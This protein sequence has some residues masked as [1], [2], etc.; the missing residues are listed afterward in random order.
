[1]QI[2]MNTQSVVTTERPNRNNKFSNSTDF[3]SVFKRQQNEREI[4]SRTKNSIHEDSKKSVECA[5][6]STEQVADRQ[7]TEN[8]V[9][10]NPTADN[11]VNDKQSP[12]EVKN[13]P[14]EELVEEKAEEISVETCDEIEVYANQHTVLNLEL[15]LTELE[16]LLGS[17]VKDESI[18]ESIDEIK[19]LLGE[20][21]KATEADLIALNNQLS[22]LLEE[23]VAITDMYNLFIGTEDVFSTNTSGEEKFNQIIKELE[24][25]LQK[26]NKSPNN[27]KNDSHVIKAEGIENTETNETLKKVQDLLNIDKI[28]VVVTNEKSK[29]S[30]NA[31]EENSTTLSEVNQ[32]EKSLVNASVLRDKPSVFTKVDFDTQEKTS[33]LELKKV[34]SQIVEKVHVSIA[35]NKNEM[36]IKLTPERLGNVAV[37]IIVEKGIVRATLYA[38]NYQVREMLESN[39]EQLRTTLIEKGLSIES[40]D[41]SV[42]Q[43]QE[44]FNR[45]RQSAYGRKNGKNE[46]NSQIDAMHQSTTYDDNMTNHNPYIKPTQFEMLA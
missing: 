42:G 12:D 17:S 44:Q 36:L 1:M 13:N 26:I 22:K 31:K 39:I 19:L 6:N 14:N 24:L 4:S 38:E 40:L 25:L 45:F 9:N 35:N 3:S 5:K 2:Q 8:Q 32:D 16:K 28:E 15:L 43:Y 7:T 23:I 30:S 11:Q 27:E 18:K 10:D 41:V 33:A 21:N 34:I 29:S 20:S 37:N 46:R